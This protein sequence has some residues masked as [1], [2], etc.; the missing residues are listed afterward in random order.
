MKGHLTYSSIKNKMNLTAQQNVNMFDAFKE[1]LNE[2]KPKRILE[3]GTAGG[4]TIQ[5][6]RDYLDEINLNDTEIKTF[7]VREHKW[8]QDMRKTN[9]EIIIEN[10]FTHSYREIEKPE[11]VVPFIQSEGRTLILCDGGSKINEFRILSPYLKVGDVIMAHDYV[12]TKENF[13]ENYKDKIWN[14]R[15][16]GDEHIQETCEKYNLKSYMQKTLDKA[17]WVC[18]IKE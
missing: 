5:F 9:I 3:I 14:W 18:K 2:Y 16:I 13:L 8:Y 11:L 1:L 10:I 7:E 17:A 4:G 15:E 12:N 6:I